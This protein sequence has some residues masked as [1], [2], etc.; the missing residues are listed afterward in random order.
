M[1]EPPAKSNCRSVH[2]GSRQSYGGRESQGPGKGGGRGRGRGRFGS[3]SEEGS[4]VGEGT[5]RKCLF[6]ECA[7]W[8][9]HTQSIIVLAK[10]VSNND[11]TSTVTTIDDHVSLTKNAER[12]K[13]QQNESKSS[14]PIQIETTTESLYEANKG[15]KRKRTKF[16]GTPVKTR[17]KLPQTCE[18]YRSITPHEALSSYDKKADVKIYVKPLVI[19]DLNGVLCHR[20]RDRTIPHEILSTL[21]FDFMAS[22]YESIRQ[23]IYRKA[24]GNVAGTPIIERTDLTSFL[25]FLDCHFTLAVW[26][27]A[28][29][30]T[31]DSIINLLFPRDIASRLL[32]VWSQNHCGHEKVNETKISDSKEDPPRHRKA[33]YRDIVFSKSLGKVWTAYPLWNEKNTLLI[34]DSPEKCPEKMKFNTLHPNPLFGLDLSSLP[35]SIADKYC[36]ESNQ[37]LQIDFFEKLSMIWSTPQDDSDPLR[38]F[39][40]KNAKDHMGWRG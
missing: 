8:C 17:S 39:L 15:K 6:L 4:S 30:T 2:E 25:N 7:S 13:G 34:D 18:G 35:N 31:A 27:S 37:R 12:G 10:S 19:L 26:T 11:D 28:K 9:T 20:V 5:G 38:D 32:F 29:K 16:K 21:Q 3:P 22:N 23:R 1:S 36:D 24:C 40:L 14:Q 33:F